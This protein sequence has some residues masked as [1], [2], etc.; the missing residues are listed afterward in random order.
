MS[1]TLVKLVAAVT[2]AVT[3]AA[4]PAQ[5]PAWWLARAAQGETGR[6]FAAEAETEW[7]VMWVA[8][9]RAQDPRWPDDY[10]AIVEGGF[11][12]HRLV[13]EPD[14]DLVALA[15]AALAAPPEADPTGGCL[16]LFSADDVAAR[17]WS[18]AGAAREVWAEAKG[19]R[20]GLF[21]FREMPGK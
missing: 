1:A 6:F 13:D 7:W 2:L 21:F 9:N 10:R 15:R 12:G 8:R 3:V 20:W 19:R 17:Q 5:D 16:Y 14:A 4:Q 18:A 11:Y